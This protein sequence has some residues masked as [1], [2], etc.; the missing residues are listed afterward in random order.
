MERRRQE[1]DR[2]DLLARVLG[3]LLSFRSV[4]SLKLILQAWTNRLFPYGNQTNLQVYDAG[5]LVSSA[6]D[7]LVLLLMRLVHL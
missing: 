4:R 6:R 5:K 2:L 7:S 1:V 3:C